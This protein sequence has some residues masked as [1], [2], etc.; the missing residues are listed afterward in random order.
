MLKIYITRHGQNEDNENGILNGHRDLPLTLKGIDQAREIA[1]K[2][3]ETEINFDAVYSSPLIRAYNTAEI[4]SEITSAP[5]PEKEALLI[6][7]DFGVMTGEKVADIEKICSP[8][9]LKAEIIT[10][11]L[12]PEGAETFPDLMD[13]AGLLLGK[14][15]EK[16]ISGNILFVTH[17]DIGKMIYAKYYDLPWEKVL[18]QFHFGNCDLLLLS[19]DSNADSAHVFQIDQHNQ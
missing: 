17:G 8:D 10:Y 12:N 11:F 9:I 14:I 19:E 1:R 16:H 5:L 13:R 6:E 18:T 15:N 7:R 2:I 4:I 3:K